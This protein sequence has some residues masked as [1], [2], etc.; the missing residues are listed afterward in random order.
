MHFFFKNIFFK[1]P[2]LNV[3]TLTLTNSVT[4]QYIYF[5]LQGDSGGPLVIQESD[6]VLC[7]R[8]TRVTHLFTWSLMV[9]TLRLVL[10]RF[11][12]WLVAWR[13]ILLVSPGSPATSAGLHQ[14]LVLDLTKHNSRDKD[15]N[16]QKHSLIFT[17]QSNELS[18]STVQQDACN[19]FM[20]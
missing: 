1:F 10:Y 20:I 6:G 5:V 11:L 4:F 12:L 18:T 14:T 2:N 13:D 19:N 16:I 8:M 3:T 9:P 15:S 17:N 7:C